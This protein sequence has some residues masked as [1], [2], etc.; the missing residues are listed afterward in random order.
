MI[1]DIDISQGSV[2]T[3]SRWGGSDLNRFVTNF[4][5]RCKNILKIDQR[6]ARLKQKQ[7]ESSFV[8]SECIYSN[9]HHDHMLQ[10]FVVNLKHEY[11]A[12]CRRTE[13]SRVHTGSSGTARAVNAC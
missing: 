12:E 11:R 1:F 13:Y 6:L 8:D 5:V 3:R 4:G 10:L 9:N 2:P 7:Q